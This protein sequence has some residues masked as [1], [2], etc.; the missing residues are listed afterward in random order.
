MKNVTFAFLFFALTAQ[1]QQ[2]INDNRA[3]AGIKP[4]K[5]AIELAYRPDTL[6]KKW[7]IIPI[8]VMRPK[9]VRPLRQ[10]IVNRR[11]KAI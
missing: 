4:I 5:P 2:C 7:D 3:A 6:P 9:K 1:A 10:V 11:I 8:A